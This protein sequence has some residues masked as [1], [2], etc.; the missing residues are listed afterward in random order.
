MSISQRTTVVPSVRLND[1]QSIPQLGFGVVQIDPADTAEAVGNALEVGYRHIDT[2]EMYHPE[3][4]AH[5]PA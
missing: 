2:A 1:G 3:T 5:I 4:F